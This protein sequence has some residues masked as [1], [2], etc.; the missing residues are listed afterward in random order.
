MLAIAAWLGE[1]SDTLQTVIILSL[2]KC[3]QPE[4]LR[5]N[6]VTGH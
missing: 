6:S 3:V 4:P 5:L 1:K 2:S